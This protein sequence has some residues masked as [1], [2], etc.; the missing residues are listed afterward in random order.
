MSKYQVI[1]D[2]AADISRHMI[3]HPQTNK[4]KSK[5]SDALKLA[6][7]IDKRAKAIN[8]R[9]NVLIEINIARE[10]SKYGISPEN[11]LD[12]A[13]NLDGLTNIGVRGLM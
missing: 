1:K 5:V 13:H 2:A 7:E 10:N 9:T 4:V 11:V 8:A 3:G 12:F 6:V